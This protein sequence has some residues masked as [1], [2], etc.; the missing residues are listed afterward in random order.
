MHKLFIK[1]KLNTPLLLTKEKIGEYF[2]SL[3]Y[4][5]GSTL[6]GAMANLMISNGIRPDLNDFKNIFISGK[7]SFGNFYF[8]YR[9]NG[10][11]YPLPFSR[12]SCK[13]DPKH[14]YIDCAKNEIPLK[15]QKCG[16]RMVNKPV[17]VLPE[18]RIS[19]HTA[20]NPE[21]QTADE[22][23][24]YSYEIIC[25]N[26]EFSG[27]IKSE[28]K[29]NLEKINM[30]LNNEKILYLGKSAS[31]GLGETE[32]SEMTISEVESNTG[33]VTQ[34]FTVTLLS[35]AILMNDDGSFSRTLLGKHLGLDN[36]RPE[37]AFLSLKNITTWNAL[38]DL[39]RETVL[40]LSAGSTFYFSG[41]FIKNKKTLEEAE[42]NGIGVRREQGFGEIKINDNR[43]DNVS[44]PPEKP[45]IAPVKITDPIYEFQKQMIK[46]FEKDKSE[47]KKVNK[48]SALFALVAFANHYSFDV[49]VQELTAQRERDKSIFKKT[50]IGQQTLGEYIQKKILDN[51]GNDKNKAKTGLL[52]LCRYVQAY[53]NK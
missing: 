4:I 7:V 28:E 31:R 13:V 20:I 53:G 52:T 9:A 48:P 24:L 25:E 12:Y 10:I 3:D 37:K 29:E 42:K 23:K 45:S 49:L 14:H 46:Q 11:D 50:D 33:N 2:S 39:P 21:T 5:P 47:L 19:M 26:Q 30:A 22:G 32:I 16:S 40:A 1:I 34:G 15:C 17:S 44:S 41:D 38:A 6:R 51:C 27:V 43:H 18:K 36:N 35:D 8:K